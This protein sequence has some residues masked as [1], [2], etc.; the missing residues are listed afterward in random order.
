MKIN[1]NAMIHYI[2]DAEK[3]WTLV[4]LYLIYN[5]KLSQSANSKVRK[6][7]CVNVSGCYL[8]AILGIMG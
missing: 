2:W 1:Y 6:V 8:K 7:Y 5:V 3:P 4:P